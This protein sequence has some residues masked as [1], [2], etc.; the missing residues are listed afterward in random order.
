M[1]A[2][3]PEMTLAMRPLVVARYTVS[4]E[5]VNVPGHI[6]VPPCQLAVPHHAPTPCPHTLPI[7][8]THLGGCGVKSCIKDIGFLPGAAGMQDIIRVLHGVSQHHNL[9]ADTNGA[10]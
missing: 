8:W 10:A 1:V 7:P 3:Q 5:G 6:P 2:L 4:C 9:L